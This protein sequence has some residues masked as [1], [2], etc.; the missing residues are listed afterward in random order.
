MVKVPQPLQPRLK[1]K[2]CDQHA[3]QKVASQ[4]VKYTQP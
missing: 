3:N 4:A 2:M 1:A